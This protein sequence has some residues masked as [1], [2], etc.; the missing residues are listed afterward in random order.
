MTGLISLGIVFIKICEGSCA[1]E[2]KEG[3]R[4]R[5]RGVPN[6]VT[7]SRSDAFSATKPLFL[8][9]VARS[10]AVSSRCISD[11]SSTC[12]H[13]VGRVGLVGPG[14]IAYVVDGGCVGSA[15]W[16]WLYTGS[17]RWRG[18]GFEEEAGR[19]DG[20]TLLP[21]FSGKLCLGEIMGYMWAAPVGVGRGIHFIPW[22]TSHACCQKSKLIVSEDTRIE[23]QVWVLCGLMKRNEAS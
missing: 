16:G 11:N 6:W 1:A 7:R 22:T 3:Y 12:C 5:I 4:E 9:W 21:G 20:E 15:G 19:E 17:G 18:A 14:A 8:P 2:V 10:S 23:C 13:G